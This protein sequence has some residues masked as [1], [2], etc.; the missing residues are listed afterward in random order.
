[1][2]GHSMKIT[3]KTAAGILGILLLLTVLLSSFYV[4]TEIHHHCSGEDCPVCACVQQCENLL[5]RIGDGSAAALALVIP[6]CCLFVVMLFAV[7]R[8]GRETLVTQ[9]IRLND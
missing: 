1:M 9:K 7:N 8:L 2:K 5:H 6:V 4:S 3:G